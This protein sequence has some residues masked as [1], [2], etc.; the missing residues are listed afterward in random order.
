M[1]TLLKIFQATVFIGVVWFF[2]SS[3]SAPDDALL[4]IMLIAGA[5]AFALTV[6]PWMFYKAGTVLYGDAKRFI[7]WMLSK[8]DDTATE[9]ERVEPQFAIDDARV[10]VLDPARRQI[11]DYT[12]RRLLQDDAER[13]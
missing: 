1:Q 12:S 6:F 5:A 4:G 11:K 10:E 7:R 13:Q 2:Y 3:E 9:G 8:G